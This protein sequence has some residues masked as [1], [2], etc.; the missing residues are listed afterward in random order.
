[1]C[2]CWCTVLNFPWEHFHNKD[3][4]QWSVGRLFL[5]I[6]WSLYILFIR[7]LASLKG[8][9]GTCSP[10]TSGGRRS[11]RKRK[12]WK[13][14]LRGFISRWLFIFCTEATKKGHTRLQRTLRY[15]IWC[16]AA[17]EER[18]KVECWLTEESA[19]GRQLSFLRFTSDGT[20]CV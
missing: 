2:V 14:S 10:I 13:R 17:I 20:F 16:A 12:S 6:V 8:S 11:Q 9:R 15:F 3:G 5:K 7:R 18:E 1:M 4:R 19:A